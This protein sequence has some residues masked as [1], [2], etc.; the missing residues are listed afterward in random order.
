[1]GRLWCE[2]HDYAHGKM[3]V[4]VA[5]SRVAGHACVCKGAQYGATIALSARP[6]LSHEATCAR[7]EATPRHVVECGVHTQHSVPLPR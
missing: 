7:T 1:M 6:Q 5:E 3:A 2:R 4:A